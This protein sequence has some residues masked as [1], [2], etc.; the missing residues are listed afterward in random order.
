[1]RGTTRLKWLRR[2]PNSIF[3]TGKK[4]GYDFFSSFLLLWLGTNGFSVD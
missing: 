3:V 4:D 1:M 2:K